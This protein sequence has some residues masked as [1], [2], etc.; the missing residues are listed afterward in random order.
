MNWKR[1]VLAD[2]ARF[3]MQRRGITS[4]TVAAVVR[5]P[6]QVLPS[7]K[8]RQIRQSLLG[9]RGRVLLRVVVTEMPGAYRVITAYDQDS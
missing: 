8:G 1:I 6:G 3:E 4:S 5:S 7:H 2:H 9:T